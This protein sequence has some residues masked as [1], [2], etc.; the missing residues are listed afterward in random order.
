MIDYVDK[1][2]R[3]LTLSVAFLGFLVLC[4][5]SSYVAAAHLYRWIGIPIGAA[6]MI[7]AIPMHILGRKNTAF[8][9]VSTSFNAISCGLAI[10]AYYIVRGRPMNI[11]TAL[12]ISFGVSAVYALLN[13]LISHFTRKK[14][15]LILFG[16]IMGALMPASIVFWVIEKSFMPSY[17]SFC[18]M[19]FF[20]FL[21]VSA[22]SIGHPERVSLRDVSFA[23][24]G[25]FVVA[26]LV[27]IAILSEGDIVD[28]FDISDATKKGNKKTKT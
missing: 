22:V 13:F 14:L 20:F 6:V 2:S 24:F 17:L 10:S 15:F 16:V 12:L 26:A 27:V 7:F 19:F 21:T 8:Y 18:I 5:T 4:S 28:G 3:T 25:S 23:S 9:I 11:I 1:N